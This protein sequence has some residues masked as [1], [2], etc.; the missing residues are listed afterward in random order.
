MRGK[1]RFL[2]PGQRGTRSDS[3]VHV[4][5]ILTDDLLGE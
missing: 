2:R 5:Q 4:L 1:W 3:K